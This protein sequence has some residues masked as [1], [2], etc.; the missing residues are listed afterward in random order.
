MQH[1]KLSYNYCTTRNQWQK[2]HL[3][4]ATTIKSLKKS[5]TWL[6]NVNCNSYL[7]KYVQLHCL[8]KTQLCHY[9]SILDKVYENSCTDGC[10]PYLMKTQLQ[11]QSCKTI[12]LQC[13][14]DCNKIGNDALT[15]LWINLSHIIIINTLIDVQHKQSGEVHMVAKFK[16][17]Y[18]LFN[19]SCIT[20]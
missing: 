9:V 7:A 16:S 3:K 15:S 5:I 2:H 6:Q 18:I 20:H 10:H 14:Y 8:T 13:H 12:Q 11:L 19:H 4:H 1:I 17:I